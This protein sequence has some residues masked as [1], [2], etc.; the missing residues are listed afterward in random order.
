M[1]LEAGKVIKICHKKNNGAALIIALL[2]I[3]AM[4]S[5]GFFVSRLNIKDIVMTTRLEESMGAYY[6]AESGIEQGLL[7]LR[8]NPNLETSLMATE[9]SDSSQSVSIDKDESYK[10]KVWHR[11]EGDEIGTLTQD[12][13]IE[14]DI[15]LITGNL[16]ISWQANSGSL[17]ADQDYLEFTVFNDDNSINANSNGK[18]LLNSTQ[19]SSNVDTNNAKKLRVHSWGLTEK[20]YTLNSSDSNYKLDSRYTFIESTGIFGDTQRK[21]QIK[22]DRANGRILPIFDFVLFGNQISTP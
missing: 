2:V 6:A 15:S 16:S 7:M 3:T 5:I 21:L 19:L 18:M 1:L 17:V 11:V 8:Y 14:Y 13:S 4:S 12:Q 22:I 10:L 9:K 20:K